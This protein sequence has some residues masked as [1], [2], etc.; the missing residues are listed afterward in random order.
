MKEKDKS[1][2]E[3]IGARI[4]QIR[5]EKKLTQE[6]VSYRCEVDRGKISKIESGTANYNITTL[7]ELAKGLG[8]EAKELLDF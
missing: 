8:V 6:E 7:V 5:I 4:L 2:L 3:A 1:I